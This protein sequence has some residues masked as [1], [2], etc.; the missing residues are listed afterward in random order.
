MRF[1]CACVCDVKKIKTAQ[2]WFICHIKKYVSVSILDFFSS[3]LSPF[4]FFFSFL[5]TS[6]YKHDLT[7]AND[8][9]RRHLCRIYP[10]M[11][12]QG[13]QI[14]GD[15]AHV[16]D[17]I[18]IFFCFCVKGKRFWLVSIFVLF[19]SKESLIVS[20]STDFFI[21]KKNWTWDN[22]QRNNKNFKLISVTKLSF[23][24]YE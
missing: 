19:C 11:C 23:S 17:Y 9:Y 13:W 18:R 15:F 16:K 21:D 10:V 14:T 1:V 6:K 22:K 4:Y 12:L 24:V 8:V 7:E 5:T 20:K 2:I 3:T